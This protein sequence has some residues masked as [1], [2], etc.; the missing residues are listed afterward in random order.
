MSE[1]N[2]REK[3]KGILEKAISVLKLIGLKIEIVLSKIPILKRITQLKSKKKR[4]AYIALA[5]VIILPISYGLSTFALSKDSGLNYTEYTVKK[6]TVKDTISGTGTVTP[7]KQYTVKSLVEGDVLSDTFEEGSTVKKGD[8]LYVIDAEEMQNSLEKANIALEKQQMSYQDS[9]EAYSGLTVTSPISGMID[10]LYVAKGDTVQSG[11]KIAK[12][13]DNDTMT[14]QISFSEG[15]AKSLYVGEPVTVTVENTFEQIS[16]KI[17]KVYNSKRVLDGYITVTDVDVTISNPGYL[18]TGTYVS[19]TANGVACYSPGELDASSEKIV[20]AKTSGTVSKLS[21]VGAYLKAGGQIAVL[22]NDDASD[23]LKG[24]QLSL[25]DS[26]LSYNSTQK[27]LDNY[28]ITAPIDGSIISKTI[29]AGDTI[30][31]DTTTEMCVIADMSK[32]TFEMSVDELDIASMKVGQKVDITADALP[33]KKFTGTVDNIGLLGTATDGVTSYPVT[34]VIENG[35]GLWPGMNVTGEITVD[36]A[37]NVLI[38]PVDAVNRGDTVLVK[39]SSY[40]EEKTEETSS[41]TK[42]KG[43]K[44][45]QSSGSGVKTEGNESGDTN[46][47]GKAGTKNQNSAPD[48]YKYVKV[49]LGLNND[50]YIEIKSGLS[51]GD[52]ILV[53]KLTVDA[54]S[55]S[56]NKQQSGMG[57]GMNSGGGMSGGNGGPPSGGGGPGM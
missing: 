54:S 12:I 41:D 32:I 42:T 53:P 22:E 24:S 5:L 18:Q 1:S 49:T 57:G 52:V 29:K 3:L 44:E 15:D 27:Q 55:S 47:S 51:E 8:V 13:V 19:A 48:G 23:T 38:I 4:N 17:T 56:Q 2:K 40:K 21:V 7:N 25:E 46:A 50:S 26:Q 39:E 37:E 33:D 11:T 20:T 43:S 31:S 30:D 10:E 9:L 35:D 16:G 34:I 36:S 45:S 14:A 28:T 6:G